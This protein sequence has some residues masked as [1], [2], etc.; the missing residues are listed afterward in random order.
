MVTMKM[1]QTKVI[2]INRLHPS[3][4]Q[5]VYQPTIRISHTRIK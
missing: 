1:G 5:T 3:S 4:R 2:N